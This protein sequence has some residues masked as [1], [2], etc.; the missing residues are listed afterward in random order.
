MAHDKDETEEVH[1]KCIIILYILQFWIILFTFSVFG[2]NIFKE[3]ITIAC[4][5]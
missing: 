3:G 4:I 2:K 5:M 1:N